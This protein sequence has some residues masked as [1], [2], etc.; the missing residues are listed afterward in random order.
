MTG[1]EQRI[2]AARVKGVRIEGADG[3]L[4]VTWSA[5]EDI[6][7]QGEAI[8]VTQHGHHVEIAWSPLVASRPITSILGIGTGKLVEIDLPLTLREAEISL[9]TGDMR[10]TAPRGD[11]RV[12]LDR[13]DLDVT[14]GA[15]ELEAK[16]GDGTIRVERFRGP[17]AIHSGAGDV[18]LERVDGKVAVQS[19]AGDVILRG[20]S[21]AVGLKLGVGDAVIDERQSDR[22]T[23][24]LGSGDVIIRGGASAE[25]SVQNG[26]GDITCRATLGLGQHDFTAGSGDI[27]VGVPRDLPARIEVVTARGDVST[28]LPLVSVGKRGPRSV[29]GRRLVGSVGEGKERAELRVRTVRGDVDLRW[30]AATGEAPAAEPAHAASPAPPEPAGD[31]AIPLGPPLADA[32]QARESEERAILTELAAGRLTVAE[33][34]LLLD[35]LARRHPGRGP[36]ETGADMP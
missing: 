21:G 12:R 17:V 8:D 2:P 22:L 3:D 26:L 6:L 5:R 36:V 30:L 11:V 19:G 1:T 28:D 34:E 18:K 29:L 33:A 32:W 25:T 10:L 27:V 4:T 13:G 24:R 7:I 31:A 15:G 9:R 35:A 23:V 20:G 16:V 14:E